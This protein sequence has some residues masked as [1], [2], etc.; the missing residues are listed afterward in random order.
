MKRTQRQFT[1]E[2]RRRI[3]AALRGRTLT[4]EHRRRIAAAMVR[5]WQTVPDKDSNDNAE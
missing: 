3:S 4:D 5:Y 2:H 1:D